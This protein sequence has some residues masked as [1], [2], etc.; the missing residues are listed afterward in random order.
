MSGTIFQNAMTTKLQELALPEQIAHDSEAFIAKLNALK[1]TDPLRI[2]AVQAYERGFQMVFICMT[3]CSATAL[4]ASL[5]IKSFSLDKLLVSNFAV[6]KD[7]RSSE[8]TE[9]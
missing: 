8:A 2:G 3:V 5:F 9:K 1:H 7:K 6:E 4:I